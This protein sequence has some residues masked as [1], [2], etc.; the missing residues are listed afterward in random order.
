M[1]EQSWRTREAVCALQPEINRAAARLRR[2]RETRRQV[3][4][5][6]AAALLLALL[7]WTAV[8]MRRPWL[9]PLSGA[10]LTL[11]LSPA[12]AYFIEE[13]RNNE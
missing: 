2:R 4:S 6:C 1:N 9:I 5:F 8:Q 11:L 13:E 7:A 12:L 3:L 10:G